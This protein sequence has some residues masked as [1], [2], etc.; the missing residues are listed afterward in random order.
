M[1]AKLATY[2]TIDLVKSNIEKDISKLSDSN[3]E[4]IMMKIEILEALIEAKNLTLNNKTETCAHHF[5]NFFNI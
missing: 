5:Q 3:I 1:N 2:K 4:K